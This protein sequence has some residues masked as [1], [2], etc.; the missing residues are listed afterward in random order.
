MLYRAA[1]MEI[2][3]DT[4]PSLYTQFK[5]AMTA[6][7]Q[8]TS[9]T[10]MHRAIEIEAGVRTHENVKWVATRVSPA[11]EPL[12][13]VDEEEQD[14]TATSNKLRSEFAHASFEAPKN[15]AKPCAICRKHGILQNNI[16]PTMSAEHFY[17]I[18]HL[19]SCTEAKKEWA[20]KANTYVERAEH[21]R[22][23]KSAST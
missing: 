17:S 11:G 22:K 9:E 10:R 23:K 21:Q 2:I 3:E 8:E 16:V 13:K 12:V 20:V 14:L 1:T 6:W 18:Q 4:P 15:T 7:R 5:E 19:Q